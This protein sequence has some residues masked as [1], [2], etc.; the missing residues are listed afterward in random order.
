MPRL[1]LRLL[2]R[3]GVMARIITTLNVVDRQFRERFLLEPTPP[4]FQCPFA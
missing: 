4:S 1:R 2:R 3:S